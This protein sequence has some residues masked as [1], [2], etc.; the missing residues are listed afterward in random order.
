MRHVPLRSSDSD[1]ADRVLESARFEAARLREQAA[2]D[3]ERIVADAQR[4]LPTP[5]MDRKQPRRR[6]A[7]RRG[8]GLRGQGPSRQGPRG[9]GLS[10]PSPRSQGLR[11]PR[12][13][14]PRSRQTNPGAEASHSEPPRRG[15]E[16]D[17]EAVP[18]KSRYARQSAKL[19]RIGDQA[20]SVLASMAGLRNKMKEKAK[21]DDDEK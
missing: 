9:L 14:S 10:R 16:E 17:K 15:G 12:L 3:A 11:R 6:S 7:A 1:E 13:R 8:Q 18:A 2:T 5:G 19:P 21:D 4:V 20:T